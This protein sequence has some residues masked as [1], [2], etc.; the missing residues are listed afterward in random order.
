MTQQPSPRSTWW[1][2][3]SASTCKIGGMTEAPKSRGI[4]SFAGSDFRIADLNL[5]IADD[6]TTSGQARAE[7]RMDMW[8]FWLEDAIDAAVV[9]CGLAEQISPLVEQRDAAE[10]PKSIEEQIDQLLIGEMKASMRA[11][12]AS[13][14]AIEAFYASVKERSPE[15]PDAEKWREKRTA[16]EKQVTETFR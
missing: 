15:H 4:R 1:G 16:R 3:N 13:A 14:F 10:D 12:T 9:A 7:L 6:G 5:T 11:I 8:P 2:G